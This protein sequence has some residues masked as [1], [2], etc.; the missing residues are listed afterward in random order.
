MDA[1]EL[2]MELTDADA[3][4]SHGAE[5]RLLVEALLD[6]NG[7]ELVTQRLGQL[8]EKVAEEQVGL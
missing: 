7:L 2:F 1:I 4:E 8:N 6:H 5:G 3:V